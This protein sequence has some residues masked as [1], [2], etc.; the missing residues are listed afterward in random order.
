MGAAAE[1]TQHEHAEE[2]RWLSGRCCSLEMPAPAQPSVHSPS[3]T[4]PQDRH[5]SCLCSLLS[6]LSVLVWTQPAQEKSTSL[7]GQPWP[8]Q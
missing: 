8:K 7:D 4:P 1:H 3:V 5:R 6:V 2:E